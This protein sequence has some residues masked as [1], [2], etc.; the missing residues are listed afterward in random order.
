MNTLLTTASG[1]FLRIAIIL[2]IERNY[3]REILRGIESYYSARTPARPG[4]PT[5]QWHLT[6]YPLSEILHSHR[7]RLK[8]KQWHP[9]GILAQISHN[10]IARFC[11]Q[12]KK[13]VVQL[14]HPMADSGFPR[15]GLDDLA[16]G[17]RAAD[18]FL[19]KGYRHFGYFELVK[20]AHFDQP[21]LRWNE[22]RKEGFIG[23]IEEFF[24][25]LPGKK[26]IAPQIS[27]FSDAIPPDRRR[28]NNNGH[29][30]MERRIA[31][32]LTT[33]PPQTAIL[34]GCDDWA[35]VMLRAAAQIQIPEHVA[36]LGVDDDNLYCN[37]VNP[38]L[39]S[40]VTGDERVG[41]EAAKLLDSLLNGAPAPGEPILLPP[42][43]ITERR[44]SNITAVADRDVRAALT[45]IEEHALENLSVK[46]IVRNLLVNRRTLESKFKRIL[47]RSPAQEIHRI[48]QEQLKALLRSGV[49]IKQIVQ[50]MNY[51]SAAYLSRAF[52]RDTGMSLTQFRRTLSR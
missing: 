51:S 23:R 6:V 30:N 14:M 32:W 49:A 24:K 43:G 7:E 39:S 47:G 41:R 2:N 33:L 1:R 45:Y 48:R 29:R 17:R 52:K 36:A 40:I 34:C 26:A 25:H 42:L 20:I 35:V 15:V 50:R 8:M 9:D 21:W 22:L 46:Q 37:L 44:S 11:A 19:N 4:K 18:Y 31:K 27:T 3:A 28:S 16:V 12:F 10:S 38:P 13:P 5:A